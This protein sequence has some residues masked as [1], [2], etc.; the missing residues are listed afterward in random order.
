MRD[1]LIAIGSALLG[2][3]GLV[4]LTVYYLK[5]YIDRKLTE[6]EQRA[7]EIRQF[8]LQK[9]KCDERIQH[10]QGR[11]F[12]WINKAIE[13]GNH[14]GDLKKAFA[15]LQEAEDEKKELERE[16]IAMYDQKRQ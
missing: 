9:A 3:S 10:A 16:T 1:I 13:T 11:M 4:G 7:E 2:G 8:R 6:D 14:N 12:F 15:E 5:R